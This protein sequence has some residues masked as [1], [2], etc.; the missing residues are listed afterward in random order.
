MGQDS[1]NTWMVGLLAID[2]ILLAALL[3][4]AKL[5]SD[6]RAVLLFLLNIV[7]W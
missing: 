6:I 7:R 4:G 2:L 5:G 1:F 3:R